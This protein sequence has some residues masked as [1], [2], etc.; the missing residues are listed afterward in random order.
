MTTSEAAGT[1][2][3]H[4][5]AVIDRLLDR[6]V[7]RLKAV[8]AL[9]SEEVERAV[10][11]V[12]RH[13][14]APE[15]PLEE[16]YDPRMVLR[17][18]YADDGTA[19]SSVSAMWVHTLMLERAHL[20]PGMR[21]LEVGG[22]GYNAALVAELVGPGGSVTSIDIDPV[23]VERARTFLAGTGYGDRVEPVEGDA[24]HGH[25]PGAPF[26]RIIVTAAASDVPPAWTEQLVDGGRLV[27]PLE[28]RGYQRIYAFT[29]RGGDLLVGETGDHAGFVPMQGAGAPDSRRAR[30][31]GTVELVT[32]ADPVPAPEALP[33][34]FAL[35]AHQERTGVRIGG[36]EPFST[37]Q[38]WMTGLSGFGL[39]TGTGEDFVHRPMASNTTPAVWDGATLAYLLLPRVPDDT[40]TYEY[41]AC[42]HGPQ[43]KEAASALAEHVRAWNRDH[44]H[45]PG[46]RFL[47]HPGLP[48]ADR[49]VR[50]RHTRLLALWDRAEPDHGLDWAADASG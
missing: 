45:G 26:D 30:V 46:P 50:T 27:L 12:P 2:P 35:P 14:F 44:R 40:E 36:M 28:V 37:L 48:D 38:M 32:D 21:V 33:D 4:D 13:A 19:T 24:E 1:A 15:F 9:C 3:A 29:K 5:P 18:R 42:G 8:G 41:V 34:V 39:L 11:T 6:A 43:A 17:T 7:A 31:T 16:V 10:R 49:V 23:V 47:V 22:G 25:P 20:A